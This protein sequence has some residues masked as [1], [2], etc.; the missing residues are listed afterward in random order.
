M[1]TQTNPMPALVP[2][3]MDLTMPGCPSALEEAWSAHKRQL[4]PLTLTQALDDPLLGRLLRAHAGSI[5]AM[6]RKAARRR[7][8]RARR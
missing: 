1:H 7:L 2:V 4:A 8:R 3:Q 6:R 5:E